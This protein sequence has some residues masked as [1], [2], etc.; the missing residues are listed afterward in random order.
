MNNINAK[1]LIQIAEFIEELGE[2][3]CPPYTIEGFFG[4]AFVTLEYS[5]KEVKY[6][7]IQRG[8]GTI[9]KAQVK[10]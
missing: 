2:F 3:D 5:D 9:E 7:F 4:S 1:L 6:V 10:H 8:D